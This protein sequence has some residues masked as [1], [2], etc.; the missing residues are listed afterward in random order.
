MTKYTGKVFAGLEKVL[1][2]T[3]FPRLFFG[4]PKTPP[5]AIGA[6]STFPVKKYGL[7]LQNIVI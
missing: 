2:E 3:F 5:P 4:K 7:G 6:L 1:Q